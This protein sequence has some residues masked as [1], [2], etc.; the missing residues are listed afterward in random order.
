MAASF[1]AGNCTL[2]LLLGALWKA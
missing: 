1:K 2:P